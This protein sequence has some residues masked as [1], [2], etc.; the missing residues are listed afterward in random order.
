M[1]FIEVNHRAAFT[2]TNGRNQ[3]GVHPDLVISP[4]GHFKRHKKCHRHSPLT[5]PCGT[6]RR[7]EMLVCEHNKEVSQK[8]PLRNTAV[9]TQP[10]RTC[11]MQLQT[12]QWCRWST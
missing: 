5:W 4:S 2:R 10:R 7:I 6:E 3:F 11:Q 8:V 9:I 12:N 1:V